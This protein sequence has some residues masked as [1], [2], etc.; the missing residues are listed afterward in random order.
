MS[1][2]AF[3][4]DSHKSK[5]TWIN[6][7]NDVSGSFMN[8]A[9]HLF[10]MAWQPPCH[11]NCWLKHWQRQKRKRWQEA[12]ETGGGGWQDKGWIWIILTL[13]CFEQGCTEGPRTNLKN[14]WICL[15]SPL[16]NPGGPNPRHFKPKIGSMRQEGGA[17]ASSHHN[18]LDTLGGQLPIILLGPQTPPQNCVWAPQRAQTW[19]QD[20]RHQDQALPLALSYAQLGFVPNTQWIGQPHP[21]WLPNFGTWTEDSNSIW[22]HVHV[23]K[24]YFTLPLFLICGR[25]VSERSKDAFS[26]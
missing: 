20:W 25:S 14:G 11:I 3:S 6:S 1:W 16:P 19:F 2:L 10:R 9:M 4:K 7:K 22:K 8:H 15:P 5:I 23:N 21:L 13:L 12:E 24:L 26:I 18:G 17:T